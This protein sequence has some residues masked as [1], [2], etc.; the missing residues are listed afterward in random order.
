M[1]DPAPQRVPEAEFPRLR[2]TLLST[3]DRCA[4]SARFYLDHE[5]DWS[6]H[7]QTRGHI[8]H[9]VAA[10]MLE[11]A[12]REGERS[13][14][15]GVALELLEDE[16]RQA[17][18]DRDCPSC[19]GPASP[20]GDSRLS[21]DACGKRWTTDLS[22]VPAEQVAQLR[23]SVMAFAKNN[24][25]DTRKL[26]SVEERIRETLHYVTD[27]G[28][29]VERVL[30]GQLDA[31]FFDGEAA[32][33]LD[34]K[35]T[36]GLP[37]ETG[38]SFGG[39]FQQRFYGWL[40][41]RRYPAVERVTLR[42]HYVRMTET[43]E[44][45]VYRHDLETI[46]LE[47]AALAERFDRSVRDDLWRPSPGKHCGFCPRPTACPIFP[48]ARGEGAIT[49]AETA[50]RFA[51][52]AAVAKAAYEKRV[53]Q[54]KVWANDHGP[55]P[56]ADAKGRRVWG[57]VKQTKTYKPDPEQLKEELRLAREEGRPP[58]LE[59]LYTKKTGTRFEQFVPVDEEP[60]P[61]DSRLAEL[62]RASLDQRAAETRDA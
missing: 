36:F 28:E 7:D 22:A 34:W 10:R 55:V 4:L 5:Q 26:V 54:L 27:D 49:D 6:T 31:L 24:E 45:T 62:L 44:A 19:G 30:S 25:F 3:Y 52:E 2:Q 48:D 18:V 14:P 8:F 21:C 51:A 60:T 32:I 59:R 39:Y 33:V 50:R 35:D 61:E 13:V 38:L 9:R 42:E 11:E 29:R 47:L 17:G 20:A 1:T 15:V 58:N 46:E 56:V 43:R 12:A 16:I 40:V 57:Y 23:I 41:M 37:P 53:K